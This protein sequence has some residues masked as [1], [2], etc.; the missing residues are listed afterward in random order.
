[1]SAPPGT[2]PDPKPTGGL[3]SE[4]AAHAAA[5][6]RRAGYVPTPRAIR[7][8]LRADRDRREIATALA[9]AFAWWDRLVA[10]TPLGLSPKSKA[11]R[12]GVG[13]PG[14]RTVSA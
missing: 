4:N 8:V 10:E 2:T 9:D 3:V 7:V 6:I 12:H 11:L 1:M 14:F 13:G 5:A